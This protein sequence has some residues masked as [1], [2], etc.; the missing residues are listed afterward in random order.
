MYLMMDSGIGGMSPSGLD[1]RKRRVWLMLWMAGL[2][3][4]SILY[5]EAGTLRGWSEWRSWR[6]EGTY[7]SSSMLEGSV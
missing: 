4:S 2:Y 6:G 5:N 7:L 3:D 1:M